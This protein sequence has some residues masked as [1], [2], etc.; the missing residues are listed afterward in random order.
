[1]NLDNL[2]T[3]EDA[4]AIITSIEEWCRASDTYIEW[5]IPNGMGCMWLPLNKD[6][7]L[8]IFY[9]EGW[10]SGFDGTMRNAIDAYEAGIGPYVHAMKHVVKLGNKMCPCFFMQRVPVILE[11][12][13]DYNFEYDDDSNT[14]YYNAEDVQEFVEYCKEFGFY[15]LIP[16]NLGLLDGRLVMVDSSH[17]RFDY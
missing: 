6:W 15:D 9:R 4:Q 14:D 7:G 10:G 17:R 5:Q 12:E 2:P 1:M 8:K 16:A 13:Y 3:I 11:D